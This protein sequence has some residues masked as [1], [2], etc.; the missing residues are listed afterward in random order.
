MKNKRDALIAA[1]EEYIRLL[2][3]EIEDSVGFLH[4]HGW[5]SSRIK[6]G[7]ACRAKIE[8]LKG[9]IGT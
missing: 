6:Q 1:L 5:E 4:A 8:K 9:L 3:N 2:G 7:K